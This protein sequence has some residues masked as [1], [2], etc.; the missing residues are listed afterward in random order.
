MLV[1]AFIATSLDGFIA[2]A[3]NSIDW[4]ENATSD[5]T[6]DYGYEEFVKVISTV[7][8]GRKTFQKIQS[9]PEWP[10]QHQRVIVLSSTMKSAPAELADQVQLFNGDVTELSELLDSQGDTHVYVDGSRAIQSFIKAG[11]LTDLIITTVPVLIGDGISLFGGP[12]PKDIRVNHV[13]TKAYQNGFVQTH[14]QFD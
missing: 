2:R 4:L 9:F 7:V 12:L 6:E 14:Y 1:S 3:D 13:S 5:A 10:F 8:M 11:L